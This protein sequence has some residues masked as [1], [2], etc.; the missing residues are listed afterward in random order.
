MGKFILIAAAAIVAAG[1]VAFGME[2]DEPVRIVRVLGDLTEAEQQQIRK[3]VTPYVGKGLITVNLAD[4]ASAVSSLS[5]PQH[6]SVRRL[7][8]PGL[9]I[10]VARVVAVAAWGNDGYVTSEGRVRQFAEPPEGRP[11]FF[12]ALATPREAMAVYDTLQ[13]TLAGTGLVIVELSESSLGEW[14]VALD[15][16][17]RVL[18][19][20]DALGSRLHRFRQVHEQALISAPQSVRYVDARYGNGVAV[21]WR[22]PLVAYEEQTA[23]GF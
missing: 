1:G 18:L 14:H 16:G 6:V 21:R 2:L 5:W 8:P 4:V 3:A 17:V 11:A 10:Q 20:R 23:Y 12:C 19:G 15:T 13:Q 22:D 7:W 9:E